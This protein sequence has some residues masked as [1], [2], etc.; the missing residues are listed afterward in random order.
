V[1][2]RYRCIAGVVR[3]FCPLYIVRTG[4][5]VD[6]AFTNSKILE[7]FRHEYL[8]DIPV[9]ALSMNEIIILSHRAD[10]SH[11]LEYYANYLR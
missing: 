6:F 8:G 7:D 11:T 2:P 5:F 3:T 4:N 9:Y 1:R 10:N